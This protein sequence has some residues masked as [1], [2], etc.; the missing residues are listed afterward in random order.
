M[1]PKDTPSRSGKAEKKQF[2][3]KKPVHPLAP[4]ATRRRQDPFSNSVPRQ[5]GMPMIPPKAKPVPM[6]NVGRG[7]KG[8]GGPKSGTTY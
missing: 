7:G 5:T 1:R 3:A 8:K 2:K 4:E 6:P